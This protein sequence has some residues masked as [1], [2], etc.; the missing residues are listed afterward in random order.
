[1]IRSGPT[2]YG[3]LGHDETG[4]ARAERLDG[5][6]AAHLERA[7]AL[8]VGIL[9]AVEAHHD[10]AR[11]EVGPGHELHEVVDGRVGVLEQVDRGRDDLDEVVRGHVRGH[12]DR[13][14]GRAVHEQVRVGGGQHRGLLELA[15][16]VR[17]EVD[18][19]LVEVLGQR[20]RGRR[21]PGLGV[22]RGGGAVIE[23]AEVAVP[24]HER[25]PQREGL[26]ETHERVVDRRVAVGVELSHHLADD[27][28]A[29]DVAAVGAQPHVGH[30][31]QDAPLDGLQPVARVGK[32]AGVDDRVRVLEERP[33]HLD[34]DIDVF[35]AFFDGCGSRCG[36]R[37]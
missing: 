17:D 36:M 37:A 4:A 23:R 34:R 10:A 29:L 14:A 2:W 8:R 32:R 28:G 21:E 25:H 16:V 5:D 1:M 11:R 20:E 33:L 12:A 26:G 15:V 9:D 30:L 27:A 6:L 22:A 19:V 24:V 3:Q 7:A 31:V 35:D 13:D 18:D